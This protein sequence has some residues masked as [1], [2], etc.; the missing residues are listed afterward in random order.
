MIPYNLSDY[1]NKQYQSHPLCIAS[2]YGRL[3]TKFPNNLNV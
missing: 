2:A 1:I 3:R